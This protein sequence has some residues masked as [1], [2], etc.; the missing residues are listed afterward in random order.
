MIARSRLNLIAAFAA[1]T[2]TS[3][4]LY[5]TF[6][7]RDAVTVHEYTITPD[8]VLAGEAIYRIIN[9][10]RHKRCEIDVDVLLIDGARVRWRFD[11]PP[12]IAP[13]PVGVR[14]TYKTPVIVPLQANPGK[15]EL[16]VALSRVCNP[17]QRI[18]PLVYV[19]PIKYFEI[20]PGEQ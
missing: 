17:I 7:Q 18:W 16:R 15:A 11:E 12:V 6:D 2:A 20:L 19:A 3:P 13:G 14:E 8:R 4:L 1:L 9:V 5:W 10:T